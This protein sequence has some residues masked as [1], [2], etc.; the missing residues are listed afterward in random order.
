MADDTVT[1]EEFLELKQRFNEL[2]SVLTSLELKRT[3]NFDDL[4]LEEEGFDD[5]E[6]FSDSDESEEEKL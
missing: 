6:D 2:L 5:E 4:S 3:V 1:R